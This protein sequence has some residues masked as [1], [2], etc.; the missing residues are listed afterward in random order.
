MA[1]LHRGF[2]AK[3]KFDR[4]VN[5]VVDPGAVRGSSRDIAR[6]VAFGVFL[7]DSGRVFGHSGNRGLDRYLLRGADS[8]AGPVASRVGR[9]VVSPEEAFGVDV[10]FG[11]LIVIVVWIAF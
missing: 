3:R 1:L 11:V 8:G 10:G 6:S 7:F 2:D 9:R 5:H 4:G